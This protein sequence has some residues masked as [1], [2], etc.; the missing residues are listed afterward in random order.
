MANRSLKSRVVIDWVRFVL[1]YPFEEVPLKTY[2]YESDH[3]NSLPAGVPTDEAYALVVKFMNALSIDG[4]G[5][6]DLSVFK[7][8]KSATPYD[9]RYTRDGFDLRFNDLPTPAWEKTNPDII[10]ADWIKKTDYDKPYMPVRRLEMGLKLDV[11]GRGCRYLEHALARDGHDWH[12]LMLKLRT[13]FPDLRVRRI[14]V[15]YDL[16]KKDNKLNPTHMGRLFLKERKYRE[17]LRQ[18]SK[19]QLTDVPTHK[20][21][22]TRRSQFKLIEGGELIHGQDTGSTFYLGRGSDAMMLRIYDKDAERV[23]SHGDTWRRNGKNRHYWYRW[24][25]QTQSD[26]AQKVFN[27]MADGNTG[28]EIWLNCIRRMFMVLPTPLEIKRKQ[29][30]KI[31]LKYD[32]KYDRKTKQYVKAPDLIEVPIWWANFIEE[33][34]IDQMHFTVKNKRSD[35]VSSENWCDG[36]VAHTMFQRLVRHILM[37]GNATQLMEHWLEQ[38]NRQISYDDARAIESQ[39]NFLRDMKNEKLLETSETEKQWAES[40]KDQFGDKLEARLNSELAYDLYKDV[41]NYQKH[42]PDYKPHDL[43]RYFGWFDGLPVD[44]E[45]KK[46][47]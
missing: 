41:K 36:P 8:M 24:E 18:L 21:I 11:Q 17:H 4:D 27:Q 40:V 10:P 14:D 9:T 16:F 31:P 2:H 32:I 34:A 39:V 28:G 22:K 46:V 25:V 13:L 30:V 42:I 29:T 45:K 35:I 26:I 44:L 12:W 7:L 6:T 37:G 23:F 15:A 33:S 43:E 1:P 3:H 20:Y 5:K 19:D 38:G 47:D